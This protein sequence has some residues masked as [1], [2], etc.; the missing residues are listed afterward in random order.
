MKDDTGNDPFARVQSEV[1]FHYQWMLVN[2]FSADHRLRER[3]E[4]RDAPSL[5]SKT[6]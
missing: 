3:V 6:E 2:D 1:R 5:R 4:G